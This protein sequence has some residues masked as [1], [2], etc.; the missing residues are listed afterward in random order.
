M[1]LDYVEGATPKHI[2][3]ILLILLKHIGTINKLPL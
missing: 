2:Y 3:N 1:L